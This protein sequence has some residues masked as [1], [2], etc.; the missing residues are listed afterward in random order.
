MRFAILFVTFLYHIVVAEAAT[1]YFL[2]WVLPGGGQGFTRFTGKMKVPRLPR[3]GKYWIWPG[4]QAE[5]NSGVLQH[6]IDGESGRWFVGSAFCCNDDKNWV[7]GYDTSEGQTISFSFV[8]NGNVWETEISGGK[9]GNGQDP[10]RGRFSISMPPR[11][12]S[13]CSL[14]IGFRSTLEPSTPCY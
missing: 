10:T 13:V 2:R 4:L 9:T 1:W 11:P 12:P 3:A 14:L 8:K 7:P 5:D 6:V